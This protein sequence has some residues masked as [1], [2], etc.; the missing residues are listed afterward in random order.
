VWIV[1]L[2]AIDAHASI[3]QLFP[4]VIGRAA[5]V[6][7]VPLLVTGVVVATQWRRQ[8]PTV[9]GAGVIGIA[10]AAALLG[11]SA[12][13]HAAAIGLAHP[14]GHQHFDVIVQWLHLTAAGV[15][16]GGLLA[17]LVSLRGRRGGDVKVPLRR[18]ATAAMLALIV[19][20]LTGT[21]RAAAELQS[22]GDLLATD[23]GRL[24]LAKSALLTVLAGLGA[25]NHF[26]NVPAAAGGLGPLRRIGSLELTF[27]A[28]IL[29]L[30]ASL[31]SVSPPQHIAAVPGREATTPSS[32]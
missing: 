6:R 4:T 27:A 22:V 18:F 7:A 20:A 23:F 29:V 28:M 30:A 2:Q 12:A 15:W 16:L 5:A 26:R 14:G 17:V 32:R 25:V 19:V 9:D 11:D 24:L 13:S 10:A 1:A 8:K 31:A 3:P 21:L